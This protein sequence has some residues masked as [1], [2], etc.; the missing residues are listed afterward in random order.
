MSLTFKQVVDE[1]L[2]TAS[3]RRSGGA[4]AGRRPATRR[5]GT[6]PTFKHGTDTIVTAGRP[7]G[8]APPTSAGDRTL[9]Q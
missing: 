7:V 6:T 5:S 3:P 8:S 1:V 2:P 4:K 9:Q